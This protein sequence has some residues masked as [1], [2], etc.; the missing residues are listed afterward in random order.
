VA[1]FA[2]TVRES[3]SAEDAAVW[4]SIA[5]SRGSVVGPYQPLMQVPPLAQ[6]VA[7][8]GSYLRFEGLL[9][10][11]DRELA[12]CAVARELGAHYEW[13]AH[14]PIALREGARP[15]AIEAVRL[16][17]PLDRLT[18]RERLVV[19]AARSLYRQHGLPEEL[20]E[21]ARTELG[22]P[23]LTEL[24]AL[25]GYYGLIAFVLAA[26]EVPLPAGRQPAF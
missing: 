6:R 16:L 21:R 2:D 22:Q 12:I 13:S 10:G 26:F 19:E 15:E 1:R 11:A 23:Q 18:D 4:D 14:A 20:F 7:D 17:G 5:G 8:L 25:V 3:L 9:P 24:V